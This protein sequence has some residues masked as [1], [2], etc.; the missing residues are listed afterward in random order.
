MF[1]KTQEPCKIDIIFRLQLRT[2]KLEGWGIFPKPFNLEEVK[3]ESERVGGE[4]GK[5]PTWVS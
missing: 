4:Y 1:S 5:V 2:L 3:D